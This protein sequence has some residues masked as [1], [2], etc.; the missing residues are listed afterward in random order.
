V[1]VTFRDQDETWMEWSPSLGAA[2]RLSDVEL[3][4]AGRLTTGTGRPGIA[5]TPQ[6]AGAKDAL[7]DFIVAPQGPLT[8]QDA[9]VAT[10]QLSV[11]IPVR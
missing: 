3:R 8:L 2:L 6:A 9:R 7:A 1:A 5:L 10:H 11:R 4:Y